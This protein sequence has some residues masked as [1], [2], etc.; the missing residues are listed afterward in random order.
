M[1]YMLFN[2]FRTYSYFFTLK[3]VER[4]TAFVHFVNSLDASMSVRSV[5]L[6][7]VMLDI[8]V[9]LDSPKLHSQWVAALERELRRCDAMTIFDLLI[10]ILTTKMMTKS[11]W[12]RIYTFSCI[13]TRTL[14][15]NT[16][17]SLSYSNSEYSKHL[18]LNLWVLVID[19]AFGPPFSVLSVAVV[20]SCHLLNFVT[21]SNLSPSFIVLAKD[22]LLWTFYRVNSWLTI[23]EHWADIETRSCT[24]CKQWDLRTAPHAVNVHTVH[25]G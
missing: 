6:S 2:N 5:C 3:R 16:G 10:F 17:Y 12:E 15:Q 19:R 8:C 25:C 4:E 9:W 20:A 23:G 24:F 7:H 21:W 18:W 1:S 13:R 14:G 22:F 11:L